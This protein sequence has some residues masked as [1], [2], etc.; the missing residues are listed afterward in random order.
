[1]GVAKGCCR[2]RKRWRGWLKVKLILDSRWNP[3]SKL[4]NQKA[5]AVAHHCMRSLL[6]SMVDLKDTA[7]SSES[8]SSGSSS[9]SDSVSSVE[10]DSM[11]DT[12]SD[13]SDAPPREETEEEFLERYA[14]TA[15]DLQDEACEEA[16]NGQ[17]EDGHELALGVMGLM[18]IEKQVLA[19]LKEHGKKL[20][21]KQPL[22]RILLARFR[23]QYPKARGY[24]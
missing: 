7:E 11:N 4:L 9:E 20:S 13:V 24:L 16:E 12:G 18:D 1:M 15:R 23:D 2:L 5:F 17:R 3:N 19:F 10:D 8:D 22:S 21:S 14:Q 6:E